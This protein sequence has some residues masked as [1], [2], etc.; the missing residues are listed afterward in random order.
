MAK[1]SFV[2]WCVVI[3]TVCTVLLLLYAVLDRHWPKDRPMAEQNPRRRPIPFFLAVIALLA[4]AAD[5]IDR[6]FF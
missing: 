6:H 1:L 4:F 3:G 5:A 2:D